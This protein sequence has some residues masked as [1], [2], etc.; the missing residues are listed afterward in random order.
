MITAVAV[1][2]YRSLRSLV[3][4]LTGFEVVTG[5]NG[6]GKSTVARALR[7]LASAADGGVVPALA[8]EGGLA[9]ALWA[10]ERRGTGPIALQLGFASESLGY[11]V[12]L[13]LPQPG[14]TLFTRDPQVKRELV[15]A[16]S[17]ARPS[18]VL[19]ERANSVVRVR[20]GQWRTL[21]TR[22]GPFESILNE[23]PGAEGAPEI[24]GVRRIVRSWRCYSAFRADRDA[25]A[26]A[27]QV[28]TRTP[29]LDEHGR[30][31]AAAIQT[32][33]EAGDQARFDSLVGA[34]FPGS[35]VRI[36]ADDGVFSIEFSRR[37]LRRPLSA[38][39]LSD[40]TLRMLLLVAALLSPSPPG[41][42]V[43]DEPEASL[44]PDLFPAL[45]ELVAAA[46]E[47][48]Q[49]VVV[50]HAAS[51]VEALERAGATRIGLIAPNGETRI[52]GFGAVDGPPWDWRQR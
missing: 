24:L 35:R 4:P 22:I 31:L 46:R 7:L 21:D 43:L 5:A 45:A 12:D 20:D 19:V 15:F 47:R 14:E 49:V 29:V 33:I 2:G 32:L 44:H 40:G 26:R 10:G 25:P 13:G 28:G 23:A 9:S 48:T 18:A 51:F 16:G 52:E 1:A 3:I 8:A 37:G 6:S 34:A 27:P 38:A 39:E 17:V 41:M 30:D 42:L 50:S 11:L 36:R